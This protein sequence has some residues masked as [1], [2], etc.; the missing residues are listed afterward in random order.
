MVWR[1]TFSQLTRN[2]DNETLRLNT[3]NVS[4]GTS[5]PLQVHAREKGCGVQTLV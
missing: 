3:G 4:F 1:K 5:N 2:A